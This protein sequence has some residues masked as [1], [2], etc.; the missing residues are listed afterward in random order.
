[1][2][3][4]R[5]LFIFSLIFQSYIF[6]QN[7]DNNI[8]YFKLLFELD[9]SEKRIP[10]KIQ[11]PG[12]FKEFS[13]N[14]K[15]QLISFQKEFILP[16]NYSDHKLV[17]GSGSDIIFDGAFADQMMFLVNN[18][19]I[20]NQIFNGQRKY[21]IDI[22]KNFLKKGVNK[23][24]MLI[25]NHS[26][27]GRLNG[28]IYL[29]NEKG[30][31]I[32]NGYWDYYTFNKYQNNIIRKPTQGFDLLSLIEYDINIDKYTSTIF[33]DKIWQKTNFPISFEKLFNDENINPTVCFRKL[34]SFETIPSEDYFLEID[35]GIDDYDRLYING[36]LI[37]ITDCF[38]CK[39]KYLVPKHY[40][41]KENLFTLFVIDKDGPG[42][43][44][45][46]ITLSNSTT[47]FNISDQ[48]SYKKLLEMELLITVK[49]FDNKNSFYDKSEF[50]FYNLSGDNL[51]FDNLL[52]EDKIEDK[53]SF[54]YY[55]LF[56][57]PFGLL[58]IFL[59]YFLFNEKKM[60]DKNQKN[61]LIDKKE[62][63]F[64][65]SDR[66]DHKILID[67]IILIEGR[68]DYVKV[69]LEEKSYLV[70]KNLK[71]FLTEL[72]TSKFVRISKSVALNKNQI[73][74][75]EKNMLFI[76]SGNYYII[77]KKYNDGIKKLFSE[78]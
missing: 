76:K 34:I 39:R 72:P 53:K 69:G 27:E 21:E 9:S 77:G 6:S 73:E 13:S 2:L 4:L 58:I 32:L 5:N 8:E 11:L 29:S 55:F 61:D 31:I 60:G 62:H 50:S 56:L 74:K 22:S 36:K 41:Q 3:S 57:I 59:I 12:P 75:I 38:N 35:K 24:S 52:I 68:K 7:T 15:T 16:N 47:S 71:T 23:I 63:I 18:E 30:K 33:N 1:M 40:L 65:R 45:S 54:N 37:G 20:N 25:I 51:N 66:A 28:D 17:I 70:R 19:F 14:I 44:K 10:V 48:W 42:G 64:I 46:K 49:N 67:S 78:N 43:V 26:N